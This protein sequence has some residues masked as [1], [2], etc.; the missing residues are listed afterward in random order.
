V[1]RA[2]QVGGFDLIAL[3]P[4]LIVL[5]ALFLPLLM[6][7]REPPPEQDDGPDDG[8]SGPPRPTPPTRPRGALPLPDAAPARVRLR[9]HERLADLVPQRARRP[10][11]EPG[12]APVRVRA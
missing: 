8:G 12:R 1:P 3:L 2:L 7:R 6:G 11:R 5:A 10:A 9:G 4:L